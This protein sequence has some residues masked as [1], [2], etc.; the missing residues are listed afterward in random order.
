MTTFSR[1]DMVAASQNAVT[2]FIRSFGRAPSQS[3]REMIIS[4]LT[5]YFDEPNAPTTRLQ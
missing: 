3:E 4:A 2:A 5:R 1:E